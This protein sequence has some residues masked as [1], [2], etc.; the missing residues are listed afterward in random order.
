[1][2]V[3]SH[4]NFG[5]NQMGGAGS[6]SGA[7]AVGLEMQKHLDS[8]KLFGCWRLYYEPSENDYFRKPG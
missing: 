1:M 6:G 4:L 5:E 3:S 8:V 2:A 7:D